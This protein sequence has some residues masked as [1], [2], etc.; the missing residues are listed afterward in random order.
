MAVRRNARK[1]PATPWS[2]EGLERRGYRKCPF[3][4]RHV[5]KLEDHIAA[6]DAGIIG[7][8]GRRRDRTPDE[9]RKWADRYKDRGI[10]D[11]R[12]RRTFVPREEILRILRLRP[13]DLKRFRREIDAVVSQES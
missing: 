5:V 10:A 6:H 9:R 1:R 4:W 8:D 3:C 12:T 2:H 7:K 11:A 13:I